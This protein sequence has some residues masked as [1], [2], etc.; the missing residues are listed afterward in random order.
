M[1]VFKL[2][3]LCLIEIIKGNGNIKVVVD[4]EARCDKFHL[5]E[6]DTAYVEKDYCDY[7]I[8]YLKI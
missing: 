5:Y 2:F 4:T 1:S 8:I 6:T 3:K 7:M